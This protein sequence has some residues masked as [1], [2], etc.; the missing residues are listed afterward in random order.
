MT[1]TW[2]GRLVAR[3]VQAFNGRQARARQALPIDP[4]LLPI[5]L[6]HWRA[7]P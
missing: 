5:D 4:S 6:A 7:L 2:L 1:D 3:L